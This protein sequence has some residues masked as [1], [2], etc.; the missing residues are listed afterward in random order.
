MHRTLD[1]ALLQEGS[2]RSVLLPHE[3]AKAIAP[4]RYTRGEFLQGA[5]RL[6]QIAAVAGAVP[7]LEACG[8]G[9]GLDG[10]VSLAGTGVDPKL[11]DLVDTLRTYIFTFVKNE[12]TENRRKAYN[13][14]V[15]QYGFPKS[16]G[17]PAFSLNDLLMDK[18][19]MFL[20]WH[21]SDKYALHEIAFQKEYS[22]QAHG[23]DM[24]KV[25]FAMLG[26]TLFS[27]HPATRGKGGHYELKNSKR[28]ILFLP[29][30]VAR[31]EY[32][33]DSA[34]ILEHSAYHEFAHGKFGFSGDVMGEKASELFALSAGV[35]EHVTDIDGIYNYY[36]KRRNNPTYGNGLIMKKII[37]IQKNTNLGAAR[38]EIENEVN[39]YYRRLRER[40]AS[41]P[42]SI[43]DAPNEAIAPIAY[44][45]YFDHLKKHFGGTYGFNELTK[46]MPIP[47]SL[48]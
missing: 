12:H 17:N 47:K 21:G 23:T 3:A 11:Q 7:A 39:A 27:T 1:E 41:L 16:F 25:S 34:I 6:A 42:W 4:K 38:I 14:L 20:T 30:E 28:Q 9:A 18:Y 48:K 2:G 10:R 13:K 15:T 24:G 31:E 46:H 44:K 43:N 19:R 37:S 22:I 29:Y 40:D 35:N 5:K 36:N 8:G 33:L 32:G 26:N 45:L